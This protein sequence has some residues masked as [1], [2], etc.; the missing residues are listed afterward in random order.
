M[1]FPE[2]PTMQ[3]KLLLIPYKPSALTLLKAGMVREGHYAAERH[4]AL[5]FRIPVH[6]GQ[7]S[8]TPRSSCRT[9]LCWPQT[10]AR[11]SELGAEGGGAGV[12]RVG[13]ACD[14]EGFNPR[15]TSASCLSMPTFIMALP[16][17]S[18][19]AFLKGT[20][21]SPTTETEWALSVRAAATS[22]PEER[23]QEEN[24]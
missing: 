5:T 18:P 23:E 24:C 16:T 13:L 8:P 2:Q 1:T 3:F 4:V 15:A 9:S 17:F 22:I 6:D 11:N 21:S 14:D 12:T 7:S 19:R 20:D 10:T